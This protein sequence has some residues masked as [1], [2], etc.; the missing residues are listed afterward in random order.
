MKIIIRLL[1]IA[2][3]IAI[4]WSG[5]EALIKKKEGDQAAFAAAPRPISAVSVEPATLEVWQR[6]LPAVGSFT[7]AQDVMVTNEAEGK[8]VAIHFTSGQKVQEGD[9]LIQLD[10]SVD[11]AELQAL[12]ANE[13]LNDLQYERAKRLVAE[14]TISKSEFDIAAARRDEAAA[15]TRAKDATLRKKAIRAPF[16]GILGIRKIDVGEYLESGSEIVSLQ[17]IDPI[18]LDFGTPERFIG[19]VSLGLAVTA[20][21]QGYPNEKFHGTITAFEP[22][23]DRATRNLRIRA[24]FSNQNNRLRSGMFAEILSTLPRTDSVITVPETAI[25]YTPYGNSVFIVED[26]DGV[27]RAVRRQIETGQAREGRIVVTR[28]LAENESVVSVGF[29]KLRNGMPVQPQ[30][31]SEPSAHSPE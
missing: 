7:A 2:A 23:I 28:G 5:I 15:M 18:Y 1:L 24:K 12:A 19:E 3:I 6:Y 25:D 22:G 31:A 16:T 17:T 26:D 8:I 20:T 29:N 27:L 4:L 30:S 11:T 13:H 10:T 9:V 21:V 14:N